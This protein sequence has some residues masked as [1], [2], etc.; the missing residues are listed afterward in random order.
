[1]VDRVL[2]IAFVNLSDLQLYLIW[3]TPDSTTGDMV[4]GGSKVLV[5]GNFIYAENLSLAFAGGRLVLLYSAGDSQGG[6]L[7]LTQSSLDL[8]SRTWSG[9]SPVQVSDQSWQSG[10]VGA[11]GAG[12]NLTVCFSGAI[13]NSGASYTAHFATIFDAG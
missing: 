4:W 9:N 10:T 7:V 3:G 6:N 13:A 12:P 2:Y 11:Y 1:M 8:R 5:D